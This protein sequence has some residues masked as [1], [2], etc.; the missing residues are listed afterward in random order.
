MAATESINERTNHIYK[1]HME[2]VL[3]LSKQNR[4]LYPNTNV[5]YGVRTK[6]KHEQLLL[7]RTIVR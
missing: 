7:F 1:C 2:A 6:T 4:G 3:F 5:P